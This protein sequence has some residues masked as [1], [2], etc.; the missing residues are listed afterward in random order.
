MVI[1]QDADVQT[2]ARKAVDAA[3]ALLT[4]TETLNQENSDHPLAIHIGVNSGIA[5]VGSTRFEGLRGVRWTFTAS[6]PVT[7]LASRLAGVAAAGQI[8]VGSETAQRL[9]D[10]YRLESLGREHLKNITDA[11]EI[12][13]ILGL[14]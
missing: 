3:L 14:S 9:G 7:N 2:H 12:Y 1:F 8:L 13:R 10:R 5:L 11:A 4:T 6:G